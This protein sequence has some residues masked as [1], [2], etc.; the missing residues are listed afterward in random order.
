MVGEVEPRQLVVHARPAPPRSTAR[1]HRPPRCPPPR[2]P[3]PPAPP[4]ACTPS[5]AA[6]PA[7]SPSAARGVGQLGREHAREQRPRHARQAVARE[8]VE[9]VV[10]PGAACAAASP[11]SSPR[12]AM[13]PMA[14]AAAGVTYPAAGVIPTRPDHRARRR[15][16]RR[17]L[18]H[19]QRCR[20]APTSP[21][22]PRPRCW[23]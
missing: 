4:R 1:S 16:H 9:R 2:W 18:A 22:P 8:D 11:C 23:C 5:C 3:P 19:P 17:H 10:E 20:A 21:A 12:R 13:A 14:S 6:L 7:S 15:A